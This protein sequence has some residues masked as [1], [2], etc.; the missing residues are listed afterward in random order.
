MTASDLFYAIVVIISVFGCICSWVARQGV[1]KEFSDLDKLGAALSDPTD[2]DKR[3]RSV[4]SWLLISGIRADSHAADALIAVRSGW[5][6]GQLPSLSELHSIAVRKERG[7]PEARVANGVAATLLIFGIAGTLVGIHPLLAHFKL[8]VAAD[9]SVQEASESVRSVMDL[10]HGLGTAFRPS[11]AALIG[12]ICIVFSRGFYVHR[13]HTL[14]RKLDRFVSEKLLTAFHLATPE[15]MMSGVRDRLAQLAEQMERRDNRLGKVIQKLDDTAQTVSEAL[16]QFHLAMKAVSNSA[17]DL[18]TNSD[19]VAA[20]L[21]RNFGSS[22]AVF[23]AVEQLTAIA[24]ESRAASEE[25]LGSS[26]VLD[27]NAENVAVRLSD[28][29]SLLE[30]AARSLPG[31]LKAGFKAASESHSIAVGRVREDLQK[32]SEDLRNAIA[33]Q[34]GQIATEITE[35]ATAAAVLF[36]DSANHIVETSKVVL[37][38]KLGSSI[39]S[40]LARLQP[41]LE[42]LK[43]SASSIH[44]PAPNLPESPM[45]EVPLHFEIKSSL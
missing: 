30:S 23:G 3:L 9:G 12:T 32:A 40:E 44:S 45:A 24:K 13:V 27:R 17:N 42:K 15:E 22:S 8:G 2:L 36:E 5:V 19:S 33:D 21:D 7:R 14:S 28:A 39:D 4:T 11:L 16:G 26:E 31:N 20:A 18:A 41:V 37:T 1:S 38:E 35:A 10:I 25:L 29:A 34:G 43:Q 6:S